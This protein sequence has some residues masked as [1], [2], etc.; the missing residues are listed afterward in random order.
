MDNLFK[1]HHVAAQLSLKQTFHTHNNK[2]RLSCV[3]VQRLQRCGRSNWSPAFQ[4]SEYH[5]LTHFYQ[6]Y[7]TDGTDN[8][9]ALKQCHTRGSAVVLNILTGVMQSLAKGCKLSAEGHHSSDVIQYNSTTSSLLLLLY[10]S[11]TNSI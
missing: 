6:N 10:N 8:N 3:P 2:K 11:F 1:I 9:T 7:V 5:I 4:V